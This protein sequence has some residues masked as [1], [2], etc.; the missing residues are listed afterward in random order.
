MNLTRLRTPITK[1]GEEDPIVKALLA[2]AG[3]SLV[4][5]AGA[6]MIGLGNFILVPLYTRYLAPAEFGVYALMDIAILVVVMVTQL[7][8]GVSYLKWFADIGRSRRGELLGSTLSVGALAAAIGGGL[9]ALAVASPLGE[10]WLQTADR[11]FV[12][13][14]LPVVVL[15]N[16]QGLLLTDLRARRRAAAFSTT[17]AVRLLAIVGASLWFIVI[18]EQGVAGVFLGRLVG[19]SISVLLLAILCLRSVTPRL[20]RS[21]VA[22]MVRYGLPL[23]WSAFMGMMLDASGRYFLSHYSTLEQVGFYGVAIKI[24]NIFRMLVYQPFGVAW[25]GLMF[26]IVKWPNARM[27]YSKILVYVFALS[28]AVAL[29]LTFF[30]PTLFAIFATAAYTPAM[31]VF[32]LVLLVRAINILEYPTAIGIYL[33]G[34]TKWFALI[35]SVG[36]ATNIL[37]NY[38]LV[39]IHG[40]FGA[41][42]A[43]LTAWVVITSL[44]ARVGQCYYPLHYEWKLF[45]LPIVP[46]GFILI[47]QHGFMPG[48]VGLHWLVQAALA[49]VVILIIGVLLAQ[50]IRVTRK[51]T[52]LEKTS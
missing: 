19:D 2:L 16:V 23:V 49:L 22:A 25:G 32:P 26:Q 39:P 43:W 10:R 3:D 33:T 14:L 42:W 45:L 35:Y 38:L 36:L 44:M 40:M 41:A 8:F 6:A 30:T 27:I 5:V 48:L 21:L 52:L 37:V 4:Y 24:G 18:Q 46:W 1:K 13:T 34:R 7:G 31:G 29:A 12:W 20:A 9:L 17:G 47:R 15:E 11:G 28:L 51:Q 50:D